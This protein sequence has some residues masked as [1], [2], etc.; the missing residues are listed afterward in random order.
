MN[1]KPFWIALQFLTRLP[2]P[3]LPSIPPP[4][5]ARA[6]LWFPVVGLLIGLVLWL[7]AAL[8]A[9]SG[10]LPGA[11]VVLIAWVLLT[12]GLHLDGLADT[13]DGAVGG[14]GDRERTLAI[15]KDPYIGPMGT[16]AIVTVLTV[17]FAALTQLADGALLLVP[18][19]ARTLIVALFATTPYVRSGGL[20]EAMATGLPSRPA[21]Y[22]LVGAVLLA[23]LLSGLAGLWAVLVAAVWLFLFRAW[24]VSRLGG[25]T[26]DTTGAMVEVGEALLLLAWVGI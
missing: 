15:M 12:G 17:K 22:V 24:V 8:F 16:T 14:Q 11:A 3:R 25:T 23:V 7:V 13:V 10:S 9:G 21:R 2:T 1:P 6:V 26:G 20:G 19:I 4:E 5:M 18:F